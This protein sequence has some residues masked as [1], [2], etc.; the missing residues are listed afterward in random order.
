VKRLFLFSFT[1]LI[2]FSFVFFSGCKKDK[3]FDK[4]EA[5]SIV[6]KI[7]SSPLGISIKTKKENVNVAEAPEL[8]GYHISIVQP[9]FEVKKEF[10][11]LHYSWMSNVKINF[12]ASNLKLFYKPKEDYLLF[13]SIRGLVFKKNLAQI[14][15]QKNDIKGK[16]R[17]G[18]P[19]K[20]FFQAKIENISFENL[21]ISSLLKTISDFESLFYELVS[22]NKNKKGS[23]DNGIFLLD[24][25]EKVAEYKIK[26]ELKK[27][28][29]N[30]YHNPDFIKSFFL[31]TKNV[32]KETNFLTKMETLFT[33]LS[34][35]RGCTF[36]IKYIGD[37][38][39]T[40]DIEGLNNSQRMEP[41]KKKGFYNFTY[42]GEM[43][44]LK[45]DH[46]ENEKVKELTETSQVESEI[47]IESISPAL[48]KEFIKL[49]Q[50]FKNKTGKKQEQA[51]SGI[52]SNAINILSAMVKSQPK[53]QFSIEAF[54]N[55]FAFMSIKGN[56]RIVKKGVPPVGELTII[57]NKIKKFSNNLE[58]IGIINESRRRDFNKFL[59][60]YFEIDET[61]RGKLKFQIREEA[62][63]MYLN[64]EPF[65][66]GK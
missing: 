1:I 5:L 63:F 4:Q 11:E 59:K 65:K 32:E 17:E 54:S 6:K 25:K 37:E 2:I 55:V 18:L 15:E 35:I 30:A 22:K 44:N 20:L 29:F 31:K 16:N 12:K 51:S 57:I 66:M 9:E 60:K 13:K 28:S 34:S 61:G 21:N 36:D 23:L 48:V 7:S 62:P 39:I 56:F 64:Q 52:S 41:S 27:T 45:V 43:K 46:S 50:N 19:S 47:Q 24:I 26:I 33:V 14:L 10:F 38:S 58:E 3:K 40:F 42:R 8:N 49:K 53:I